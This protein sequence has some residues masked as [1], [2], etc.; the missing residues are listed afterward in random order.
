MLQGV[1]EKKAKNHAFGLLG[2]HTW[3]GIFVAKRHLIDLFQMLDV[4]VRL[5]RD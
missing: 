1:R 5:M 3:Q 4:D 2:S